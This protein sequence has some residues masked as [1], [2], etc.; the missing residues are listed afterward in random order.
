MPDLEKAYQKHKGDGLQMV[1]IQLVGLDT[2]EA[3]QEFVD[4]LGVNYALGP[5]ET[6]EIVTM[7]YR[8]PGFPTTVFLNP[9]HSISRTWTGILN[10]EN[11]NESN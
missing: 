4:T 7:D 6:G 10:E 8:V 9:D 1:G 11:N 5:D 3:G 2:V